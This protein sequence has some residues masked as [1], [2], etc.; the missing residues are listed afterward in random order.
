MLVEEVQLLLDPVSSP[1]VMEEE[2][3]QVPMDS[4]PK[5][6]TGDKGGCGASADVCMASILFFPE[7]ML[8][9]VMSSPNEEREVL[10]MLSSPGV[11]EGGEAEATVEAM[12]REVVAESMEPGC[13][14]RTGS[15][16]EWVLLLVAATR[17]DDRE[18]VGPGD[19]D[20]V[21]D[22]V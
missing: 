17:R 1:D 3:T 8:V 13:S 4:S 7:V 22:P 12:A 19:S 2:R 11:S 14:A 15:P 20:T 21:G 16:W 5:K 10:S 9:S 18:A 6:N